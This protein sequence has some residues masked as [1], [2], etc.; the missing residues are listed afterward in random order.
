[1][2]GVLVDR[3]T[4]LD[5][6]IH[7]GHGHQY[8]D[9]VAGHRLGNGKLVQVTGVVVV[10]GSPQQAPEVADLAVAAGRR[11]PNPAQFAQC[12]GREVGEQSPLEHHPAGDRLQDG[13]VLL[14][15]HAHGSLLLPSGGSS[16]RALPE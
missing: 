12:F 1:M 8:L 2:A 11:G 10:D 13:T 5:D 7:V 14:A 4:A 16:K 9:L 3:R 15:G 6:R